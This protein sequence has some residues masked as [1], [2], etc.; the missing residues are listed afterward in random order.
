MDNT[1]DNFD[2]L[3]A[4]FKEQVR[5]RRIIRKD[6]YGDSHV[7]TFTTVPLG[8]Q[9]GGDV[10]FDKADNDVD[11]G[12]HATMFVVGRNWSGNISL[13]KR[14][15]VDLAAEL[16]AVAHECEELERNTEGHVE[17]AA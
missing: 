4:Q 13:T 9:Y 8:R 7:D 16:M 15:M 12:T 14:D 5:L 2:A 11:T 3:W 6:P 1:N 17:D 10:F